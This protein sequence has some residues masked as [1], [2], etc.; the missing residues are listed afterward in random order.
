MQPNESMNE[1][2]FSGYLDSRFGG[3]WVKNYMKRDEAEILKRI[4][5]EEK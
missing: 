5:E 3:D 4:K 1:E 2:Q